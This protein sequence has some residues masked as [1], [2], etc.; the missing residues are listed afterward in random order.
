[1]AGSCEEKYVLQ[2][3]LYSILPS[4]QL[5]CMTTRSQETFSN[6]QGGKCGAALGG[7]AR[8]KVGAGRKRQFVDNLLLPD[9][10]RSKRRCM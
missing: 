1:M 3:I 6:L 2:M 10:Q 5:P 4:L 8:V 7:V 9:A